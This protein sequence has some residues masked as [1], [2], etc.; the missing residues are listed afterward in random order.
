MIKTQHSYLLRAAILLGWLLKL[1]ASFQCA[2]DIPLTE[3]YLNGLPKTTD[4]NKS[5]KNFIPSVYYGGTSTKYIST[6]SSRQTIENPI[7]CVDGASSNTGKIQLYDDG[8]HGDDYA[9]DG[10][11]TRGCVHYC[12]NEVDYSDVF[13]FAMGNR[14][15]DAM[16]TEMHP[17]VEG[18]IPY[19]SITAPLIPGAKLYASSHAF[20]FADVD[21]KYYPEFPRPAET[22]SFCSSSARNVPASALLQIFGDA[23]D[24]VTMLSLEETKT[25]FSGGM[26]K[27]NYWDRR[28]GPLRAK[29]GSISDNCFMSMSGVMTPRLAGIIQNGQIVTGEGV[30]VQIHE[31]LHGVTGF[32]YMPPIDQEFGDGSH[33]PFLGDYGSLGGPVW[34][35]VKGFPDAVESSDGFEKNGWGVKMFANDDCKACSDDKLSE[36]CTFRYE[37]YPKT[38]QKMMRSNKKISPLLLYIAGM[39]KR[40]DVEDVD[41][42]CVGNDMGKSIS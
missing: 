28:F 37:D 39:I 36:C 12:A 40:N 7:V 18:T 11:Y 27:T 19:E 38:Y 22:N 21:R 20:F 23:F 2:E 13:G 6:D 33:V 5:I 32:E 4:P 41:Y 15:D 29:I 3:T 35:W 42:Y 26:C 24:F 30:E 17:S 25:G 1:T 10:V 8:T 14:I 34:D 16:L 9:N 31:M